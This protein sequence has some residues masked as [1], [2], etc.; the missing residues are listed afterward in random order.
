VGATHIQEYCITYSVSKG[1]TESAP[2]KQKMS[3][4]MYC[5]INTADSINTYNAVKKVKAKSLIVNIPHLTI[6]QPVRLEK[7]RARIKITIINLIR[8]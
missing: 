6:E 5:I 4:R 8:Q 7:I 2:D 3:K 1:F